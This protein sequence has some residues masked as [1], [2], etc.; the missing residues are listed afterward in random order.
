MR[1]L[2]AIRNIN[3]TSSRI[4]N[5]SVRQKAA[6]V[7]CP[8]HIFPAPGN[9]VTNGVY[10]KI[11]IVLGAREAFF[12]RCGD[13]LAIN[14]EASGRVVIERR[15]A[16][17]VRHFGELNEGDLEECVNEWRDRRTL[18]QHQ[19]HPEQNE[20]NDYWRQPILLIFFHELPEFADY[21]CFRHPLSNRNSRHHARL[22]TA[23]RYLQLDPGISTRQSFFERHLGFP[24]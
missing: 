7:S 21:L 19:Q 10:G 1:Y 12:L 2:I 17:N 23:I 8:A 14:H 9:A 6:D 16:Q 5:P 18:C 4:A 15:Y 13:N 11:L 22:R 24:V 20:R 3:R